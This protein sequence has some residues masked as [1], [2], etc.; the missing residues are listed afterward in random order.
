MK[1]FCTYCHPNLQRKST[2]GKAQYI[3]ILDVNIKL[4]QKR[5]HNRLK[6]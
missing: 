3:A 5:L 6:V 2:K 4:K 1:S